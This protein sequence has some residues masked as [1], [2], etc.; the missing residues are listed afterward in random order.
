MP[1]V[2]VTTLI[3]FVILVINE[4]WWRHREI[5]DEFSRKF[6]HLTVGSFVAFWPFFLSWH[7]IEALS[8]AFLAV[9]ILS[10]RLNVFRALHSVQRPTGGE[11][12]FALAVGLIALITHDKW[13]YAAALLQ[14]GLADGLAAIIGVQY[15]KRFKY[16]I[17][18][19]PKS[20]IGT[21]TFFVISSAILLTFRSESGP[22]LSVVFLLAVSGLASIIENLAVYGLDNLLVPLFVALM[23]VN[24]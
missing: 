16:L 1:A 10:K 18:K 5:H 22:H 24:H 17:F 7:Q 6:V 4:W 23:L 11:L 8:A 19:H 20:L 15:G 12:F 3:I 9:V 21:L 2:F 14:M 13:I